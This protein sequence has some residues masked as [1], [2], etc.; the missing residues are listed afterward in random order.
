MN[1]VFLTNNLSAGGAERVTTTLSNVWSVLGVNVV[2]IVT[3]KEVC[4]PFYPLDPRVQLRFLANEVNGSRKGKHHLHRLLTLRRM[5]LET[6]PDVVVSFLPNVNIAAILAT[7]FTGIPCVIGERSDPLDQPIGR[8]WSMACQ[9]LYRYADAV[10]VQT[11]SVANRI[12][13]IYPA[14]KWV[15]VIPNPL[16]NELVELQPRIPRGAPSNGRRVLLSVG[17]LSIEKRTGKIID[18]FA[19]VADRHPD[20]DLHLVGDGPL[21]ETLLQ[22]IDDCGLQIGRVQLLGRS[23]EPWKL[24][25]DA[26]AF[27]LASA[28]EGFPNALLEAVALGL[29][30]ISTDCN[31]GPREISDNGSVVCLVPTDDH[32]ALVEALDAMMGDEHLRIKL[33]HEGAKSVRQRFVLG[34]VLKLWDLLFE[35]VLAARHRR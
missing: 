3:F 9:M 25:R 28:Y 34:E 5:I 21:R 12:G 1:L 30:S 32:K 20:W 8:L 31:S 16:P 6:R 35:R 26:D 10:T 11:D 24:M 22:Q 4:D 7:A 17:R 14:L 27:V 23:H 13:K 33:S 15:A 29:P 19:Q 2:L 18:A